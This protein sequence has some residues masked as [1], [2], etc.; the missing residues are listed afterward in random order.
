MYFD[1]IYTHIHYFPLFSPSPIDPFFPTNLS[2][3]FTFFYFFKVAEVPSEFHWGC[4]QKYGNITSSPLG[5][6][7]VS[8][9]SINLQI[10]W[11]GWNPRSPS[12][13]TA[14]I[15][16]DQSSAVLILAITII[17]TFLNLL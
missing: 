15:L 17:G 2:S 4:L 10:F 16:M 11:E 12:P 9:S 8:S 6:G 14:K 13:F 5:A 1:H 7:D 3:T